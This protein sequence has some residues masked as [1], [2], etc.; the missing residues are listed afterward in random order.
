VSELSQLAK[1]AAAKERVVRLFV[2][3]DERDWA[4]VRSCFT[5]QVRFD[6]E[7]L[8]G[9]PPSDMAADEIVGAWETG[10]SPL[11]AVHHQVG[12]FLITVKGPEA[13]VSCHGI[14]SHYL[15][16]DSG[17]NTRTFVGTY[18]LTLS[19]QGDD[20]LIDG[21]RFNLKYIDGNA[22]LGA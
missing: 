21:F 11:Q 3:T 1:R 12:N 22:E 15:P 16:N 18:D 13:R 14:A 19:L 7:S 4:N 5:D 6:M 9:D 17:R 2:H 8:S 10:L 20:W